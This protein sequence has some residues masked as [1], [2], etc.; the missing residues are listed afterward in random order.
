[1]K[2]TVNLKHYNELRIREN[3][4]RRK[5]N[6]NEHTNTHT[7]THIQTYTV[8]YRR[9]TRIHIKFNTYQA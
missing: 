5:Y 1:M 2:N 8:G 6:K 4:T 9:T 3:K 7:L